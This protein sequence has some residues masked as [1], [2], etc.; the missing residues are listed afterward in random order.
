MTLE[1]NTL[2]TTKPVFG[3]PS[4]P[5][6]I[7]AVDVAEEDMMDWIPEN[8]SPQRAPENG[9]WLRPQ[10]FFPPE[11]ATGLEDLFAQAAKLD[12]DDDKWSQPKKSQKAGQSH[13][14]KEDPPN[15]SSQIREFAIFVGAAVGIAL[16]TTAGVRWF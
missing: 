4:F 2:S 15:P 5:S 13:R 8:A 16:I 10:R 14:R 9:N 12:T 1:P 7:P 3:K 11:K 6:P